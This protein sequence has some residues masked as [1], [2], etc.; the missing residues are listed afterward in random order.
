MKT[1]AIVLSII[2]Y[3]FTTNAQTNEPTIAIL[4]AGSQCYTNA[5]I[6]RVTPAY[7]V[8]TYDGGIVQIALSNLPA[9]Y[10]QKYGY[11]PTDAARYLAD[12]KQEERQARAKVLAQ[13]TAYQQSL[14]SLVGTN[15]PVRIISINAN[16]AFLKCTAQTKT[17]TRDINIRNLPDSVRNFIFRLNQ[18]RSDIASYEVRVADY[19][20]AAKNADA[21]APVAAGGDSD[22]VNATMN[23]R[24]R[25]NLMLNNAEDMQKQ[26]QKM[27]DD[28]AAMESE[29]VEKTTVLAY[30]TGQTYEQ[31]EIWTCTGLP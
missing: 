19:T 8:V 28:L 2:S 22:Y 23:Q 3:V 6:T 15:Q 27:K 4:T 24:A 20:R 16:S 12:K 21:V 5:S 11:S 26:L 14:A 7:V 10:Q 30:P 31:L 17:G 13:Q 9:E 25:V 18:L 29:S 1:T